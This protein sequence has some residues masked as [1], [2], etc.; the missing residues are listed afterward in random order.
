MFQEA[1]L[2]NVGDEYDDD[3]LKFLYEKEDGRIVYNG[4]SREIK[5]RNILVP[6]L[7]DISAKFEISF[8]AKSLGAQ[9]FLFWKSFLFF[10]F[11]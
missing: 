7:N 11:V 5:W 10:R 4:Q 3:Y 2:M 8:M 1:V 6:V 9:N